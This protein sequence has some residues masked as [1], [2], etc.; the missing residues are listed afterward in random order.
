M[1][2][3]GFLIEIK[4]YQMISFLYYFCFEKLKMK[5]KI[6]IKNFVFIADCTFENVS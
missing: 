1:I 5:N 6:V 4:I 3:T 2:I